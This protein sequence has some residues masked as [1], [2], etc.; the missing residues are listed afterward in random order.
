MKLTSTKL[1]TLACFAAFAAAV[2]AHADI[3]EANMVSLRI[4]LRGQ[5]LAENTDYGTGTDQRGDRTDFRFARFR[6]TL[7]GMMDE[8][9]GFQ[10]NTTS[11]TSGT[12][13]GVTGYGVSGQDT[14]SNDG[15]I[16][17]HDGYF[18][19][20][21]YP[22]LNFKIGLTK[23]PLTRANLDGCF[24]PLTMD[25]SMFIFTAYGT[26]PAKASRDIGVSFWG[27]LADGRIVYQAAVFQ[28]REGFTRTTNPMNQTTVVSSQTPSDNFLYVGRVHYSF[29]DKEESSGYE[30]SYLGDLKIL[31]FGIGAAY[32]G[33]A[34]Y[35]NVTSAGFVQ[36]SETVDYTAF[37]ADMMFE[38]PTPSGTYTLTSAYLKNHFDDA[39][40]TN[41]NPG[42]RTA[43]IGGGNGQKDGWY[44]RGAYLLPQ[45]FGKAGRV[46][47]Y[48]YYEN[49]DFASIA[50]VTEQN[51]KQ[52]A[53]GF[54]WYI[55]GNNNV[56]FT[57]EYQITEFEKPT[58]LAS[59]TGV[60]PTGFK[61]TKS[62]R[63]MFQVAF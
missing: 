14:D 21:Y 7:T 26:V 56:R 49:W 12:K 38:Y 4:Q 60:N 28:G 46:Q 41:L 42:D 25:R 3:L 19:A 59:G 10:I 15:N 32:E 53:Y 48:A 9:Y 1:A 40:K 31:T 62:I 39:Y 5:L 27:K 29:W 30:G 16:R 22:W 63:A 47:P 6:L 44:V 37:T 18:I 8:T 55:T 43:N 61:E 45:T 33:A 34:V 50:G 54:N 24:D 35:K 52:K 57:T 23:N 51:I 17:L 36:N 20:N 58:A 11:I 13:T 2:P